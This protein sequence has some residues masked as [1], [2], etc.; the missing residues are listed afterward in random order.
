ML[1]EMISAVEEPKKKNLPYDPLKSKVE[2]LE[3]VMREN[4]LIDASFLVC[5]AARVLPHLLRDGFA[6]VCNREGMLID[7]RIHFS[8]LLTV[9]L[10]KVTRL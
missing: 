3:R 4:G 2:V 8:H 7:Y 6:E 9:L 10:R 1:T 5:N